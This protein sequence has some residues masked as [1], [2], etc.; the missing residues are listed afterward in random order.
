MR[1]ERNFHLLILRLSLK[2]SL[3]LELGSRCSCEECGQ[4]NTA[5]LRCEI[6]NG[7][8]SKA[9]GV[10]SGWLQVKV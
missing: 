7:K 9:R 3:F 8:S 5:R 2:C 4:C 10:A 1:P 6:L